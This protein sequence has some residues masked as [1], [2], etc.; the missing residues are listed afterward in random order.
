MDA[1]FPHPSLVWRPRSRGTRQNDKTYFV[2]TRGKWLTCGENFIIVTS[3]VFWLIHPCDRRTG[4]R[5]H[6]A[7]YLLS[8]AKNEGAET[9]A[10]SQLIYEFTRILRLR[11]Y[12]KRNKQD[13]DSSRRHVRPLTPAQ[14]SQQRHGSLDN[15]AA[16]LTH[17]NTLN[18]IRTA[19]LYEIYAIF[20]AHW[21]N[22][23]LRT[24]VCGHFLSSQRQVHV[25]YSSQ[26]VTDSR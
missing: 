7:R 13:K 22:Y 6:I 9:L 10:M 11:N 17:N 19:E 20:R 25:T 15:F 4:G 3:R 2:N 26:K 23:W 18:T 16:G 14:R 1:C 5:Q 12:I 21:P 24:V 8:R